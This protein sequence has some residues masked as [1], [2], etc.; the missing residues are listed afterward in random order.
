MRPVVMSLDM[1]KIGRGFEGLVV[2]VEFL[3][4]AI[5]NGPTAPRH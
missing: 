1:V 5:T 3:Q 4:P 2:P